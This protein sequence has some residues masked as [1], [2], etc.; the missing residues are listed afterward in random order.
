MRVIYH[1]DPRIKGLPKD[2]VEPPV[3]IRVGEIN[4]ATAKDFSGFMTDA[5][6]T[7][8]EIIPVVVD[9]Y[10][11]DV[12][13]L[14]SILSDIESSQLPVATIG[15]GKCMS[16]GAVLLA[17]GTPGLRFG[18]PNGTIMMHEVSSFNWGKL[19]EMKAGV[20]EVDRLNYVLYTKMA[21]AC[22]M[23]DLKYF[24]KNIEKQ[25]AD[26]YMDMF[27]AKFL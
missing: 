3:I 15:I 11:G 13:A 2:V 22:G 23:K 5:Y 7:G 1:K 16:A 8:Q 24:L 25:R 10:G 12:Y 26:W 27:E 19:V 14:L 18:D 17:H 4:E 21:A 6:N 9:S 20:Q